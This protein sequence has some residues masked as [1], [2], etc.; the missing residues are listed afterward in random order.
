[1]YEILEVS[2][3]AS[4]PEIKTAHKRL[5]LA[6][7]SGMPGLSREDVNFKLNLLDVALHTLS[8]P[9]LR[10]AYDAKLASTTTPG[11]PLLPV[12]ANA[13]TLVDTAKANQI[14]AAIEDSQKLAA[15]M[16]QINQF[17][18]KE[19]SSTVRMSVSSLKTILRIVIGL[20]VLGFFIRMGQT[21]VAFRHAGQPT[22]D[23]LKA[24]DKLVILEYYKKHGVRPASRAEAELLE[25]EFRRKESE[26]SMAK[27][28]EQRKEREYR[29]FVEESRRE[30]EYVHEDLVR[31][32]EMAQ[33]ERAQRQRN[34]AERQRYQEEAAKRA[35]DTRIA[36]ERRK[37]GLEANPSTD[38]RAF[39]GEYEE[40]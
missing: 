32:E 38:E 26:Q 28:E 15:A 34:E 20:I 1:M 22:S 12:K 30:G 2:P 40:R 17:P 14:V 6:L 31:D 25:K 10:D 24:E 39:A 37:L 5:S 9:V 11:N 13:M 16:M 29:R 3:T 35:E 23:E 27:A 18:V 36:N 7:M 19:V 33:R 4:F 8:V 21:A